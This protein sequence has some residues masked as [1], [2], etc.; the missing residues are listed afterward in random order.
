MNQGKIDI[1]SKL[2]SFPANIKMSENKDLGF[3]NI[4]KN[5]FE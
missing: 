1:S 5:I 2:Y 3:E 4:K